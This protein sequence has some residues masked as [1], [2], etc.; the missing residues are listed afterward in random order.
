LTE[1]LPTAHQIMMEFETRRPKPN[2]STRDYAEALEALFN[3]AVPKVDSNIREIFLKK[4]FYANLPKDVQKVIG[5]VGEDYTW[6]ELVQRVFTSKKCLVDGDNESMDEEVECNS[7]SIEQGRK[8]KSEVHTAQ[9]SKRSV[10]RDRSRE[11]KQ[12][13]DNYGSKR[14]KKEFDCY[15]CG[16]PNHWRRECPRWLRKKAMDSRVKSESSADTRNVSTRSKAEV[17]QH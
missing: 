14:N 4:R 6:K 1:L 16:D 2:E 13:A 5:I 10:P 12:M 3:R 11:P 17:Q 7:I 9:G 15:V 8:I